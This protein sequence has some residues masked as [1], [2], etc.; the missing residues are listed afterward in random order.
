MPEQTAFPLGFNQS[1]RSYFLT[2]LRRGAIGTRIYF[3]YVSGYWRAYEGASYVV[4]IGTGP[5]RER[6]IVREASP[7]ALYR[8]LLR[9]PGFAAECP[10]C[11][12]PLLNPEH[13]CLTCDFRPTA[14]V[15]NG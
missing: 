9:E 14:E 8:R 7:G 11:N 1:G 13:G 10:R 4:R 5:A 15:S 12:V 3:A 6:F 2:G